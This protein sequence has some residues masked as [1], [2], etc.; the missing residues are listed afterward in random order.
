MSFSSSLSQCV[1]STGVLLPRLASLRQCPVPD[2]PWLSSILLLSFLTGDL[3]SLPR[4]RTIVELK[5]QVRR[6][7]HSFIHRQQ[8]WVSPSPWNHVVEIVF[9]VRDVGEKVCHRSPWKSLD[10]VSHK[11][12]DV[13]LETVKKRLE[14][15]FWSEKWSWL[16]RSAWTGPIETRV[17]YEKSRNEE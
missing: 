5:L 15:Y 11:E 9:C 3:L 17:G 10:Y 13:V 16:F 6:S 2:G 8:S 14:Y 7:C 12:E 4:T 1:L